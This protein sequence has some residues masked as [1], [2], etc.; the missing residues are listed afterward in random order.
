MFC[1]FLRFCKQ[2]L[3]LL[4]LYRR[5]LSSRICYDLVWA[6]HCISLVGLYM[7]VYQRR[8]FAG[9]G[10]KGRDPCSCVQ[11]NLFLWF[12]LLLCKVSVGI[13]RL[14]GHDCA[15]LPKQKRNPKSSRIRPCFCHSAQ[16]VSSVWV[17]KFYIVILVLL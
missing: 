2:L 12:C 14:R 17:L 4:H 6:C 9:T 8:W 10:V 16:S 11:L 5:L 13:H 1:V 15:A 7:L 3:P